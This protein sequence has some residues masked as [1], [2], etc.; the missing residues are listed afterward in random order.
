ML[1]GRLHWGAFGG[2]MGKTGYY[3]LV[4]VLVCLFVIYKVFSNK[5]IKNNEQLKEKSCKTYTEEKEIPSDENKKIDSCIGEIVDLIAIKIGNQKREI[6]P[7]DAILCS[8]NLIGMFMFLSFDIKYQELEPGSVL[9]SNE[10]N[11]LGPKVINRLLY[12][13]NNYKIEIDKADNSN[14]YKSSLTYLEILELTQKDAMEI[15]KKYG[16]DYKQAMIIC[17]SA[18]AFIIQNVSSNVDV[19][20]GFGIATYGIVQGSKTI[21]YNYN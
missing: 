3:I 16:F 1:G 4:I 9:L 2:K 10:A 8:G 6:N 14:I 17:I 18:T 12:E 20:E 19:N 5:K 15:M 13:L 11:E 21:P 7:R